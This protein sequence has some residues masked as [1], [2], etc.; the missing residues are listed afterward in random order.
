[1]QLRGVRGAEAAGGIKLALEL[2]R[3]AHTPQR[4]ASTT[5]RRRL[6]LDTTGTRRTGRSE[7]K[8][9]GRS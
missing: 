3:L 5:P 9:R 4:S 7:S 6:G 1:V 2:A 8:P